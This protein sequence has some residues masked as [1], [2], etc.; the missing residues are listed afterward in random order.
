MIM[1]SRMIHYIIAE[2]IGKELEI[3][4]M[5]RFKIGSICPDMSTRDNG[6][7]NKT[8][9]LKI[10]DDKKG[11]DWYEFLDKY[12][13]R[14]VTDD[15]YLGILCHLITDMIWFHEIME[16]HIRAKASSKEERQAMY[17]KGYDDFHRLN[18]ILKNEF[19]STYELEE[20]RNIDLEGINLDLYDDVAGGL[21]D[22]FF[23]DPPA[24]KS[25]LETYTYDITL[26]AI[27]LSIK[28]CKKAIE[29]FREGREIIN[30]EQYF[31]PA[32]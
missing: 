28:E 2:E 13:E 27:M 31:V 30:P 9:F 25:D 7:K 10:Y 14:A 6:S 12:G 22:D 3:R 18:Y 26:P 4:D 1:P 24:E 21:Y 11:G 19:N 16:P 8:H 17:L 29:D 15:L 20:D 5:N 23:K 32:K